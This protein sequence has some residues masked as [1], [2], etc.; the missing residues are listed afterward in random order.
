MRTADPRTGY[1][2]TK[3]KAAR[4]AVFTAASEGTV[5]GFVSLV[6]TSEVAVDFVCTSEGVGD[7][8][9]SPD[10]RS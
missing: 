9:R 3:E 5:V 4:F 10:I 1:S 8:V 7:L 2:G 6:R